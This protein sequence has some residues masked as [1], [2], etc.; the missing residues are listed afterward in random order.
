VVFVNRSPHR[1]GGNSNRFYNFVS[2]QSF[3]VMVV[4]HHRRWQSPKTTDVGYS[5]EVSW[6]MSCFSSRFCSFFTMCSPIA[7]WI[8]RDRASVERAKS[9]LC[10]A[11]SN[12]FRTHYTPNQLSLALTIRDSSCHPETG[13][14]IPAL[15]RRSAFTVFNTPLYFAMAISPST[16][17]WNIGWQIVNQS[18]NMYLSYCNRSGTSVQSSS[19]I[20][21][22]FV[23]ATS[24][25][26][27]SFL[28]A[29]NCV[30]F[31]ALR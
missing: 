30:S 25:A 26:T 10:S 27:V 7:L 23:A 20:L 4:S 8:A 16:H 19:D 29:G 15:F 11:R 6:D 28:L 1:W 9:T 24:V 21:K 17:A 18:Y 5:Q 3:T 12:D 31:C 13:E 2:G 22:S 14:I